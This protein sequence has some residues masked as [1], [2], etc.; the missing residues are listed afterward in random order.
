MR[1]KSIIIIILAILAV[2]LIA[3]NTAVT[4]IQLLFWQV[5]MSRIVLIILLLAIGFAIGFILAKTTGRKHPPA[6]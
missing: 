4:P 3:Q 2:V 1:V 5:N 6:Q